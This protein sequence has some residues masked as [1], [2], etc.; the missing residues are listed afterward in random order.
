MK[1][2]LMILTGYLIAVGLVIL[3][4]LL[5]SMIYSLGSPATVDVSERK[6]IESLEYL[7]NKSVYDALINASK[8]IEAQGI[9]NTSVAQAILEDE[10]KTFIRFFRALE[11][12]YGIEGRLINITA[13]IDCSAYNESGNLSLWINTTV[14]LSYKDEDLELQKIL[15]ISARR[16]V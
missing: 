1:G 14:N 6:A 11:E 7:I 4:M 3:I 13:D 9:N 15:E 12:Y 16:I 8:T 10:T 2:Q 5:D